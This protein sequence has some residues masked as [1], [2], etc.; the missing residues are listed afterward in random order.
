MRYLLLLICSAASAAVSL[1]T[2]PATALIKVPASTIDTTGSFTI[3]FR[4]HGNPTGGFFFNIGG[5]KTGIGNGQF[6]FNVAD[7]NTPGNG[8]CY[9]GISASDVTGYITRNTESSADYPL[10]YVTGAFFATTT[11]APIGQCTY[12]ITSVASAASIVSNGIS[13]GGSGETGYLDFIRWYPGAVSSRSGALPLQSFVSSAAPWLDYEFQPSSP[14]EDTSGYGQTLQ[15]TLVYSPVPTYNPVC[16]AGNPQTVRAGTPM[17]LSAINS[18]SLN[19]SPDLTF[20]WSYAGQGTDGV[21]QTPSYSSANTV[22][23]IAIGL[24]NFGSFNTQLVVTDSSGNSTTCVVHNGVVIANSVGSID[25][26][27]EGLTSVQQFIIGPQVANGMNPWPW[28]ETAANNERQLQLNNLSSTGMYQP[29]WRNFA[30]GT[31]AVTAGT[32]IFVGNGT[33]FKALFCSG[34]SASDGSYVAW[35]FTGTDGLTHYGQAAVSSCTDDNHLVVNIPGNNWVYPSSP[36]A[37][38]PA[39]PGPDGCS[40][41]Q[42]SR[43]DLSGG[44]PYNAWA[45]GGS[46]ANYYDNVELFLIGYWDSGIDLYYTGAEEMATYFLEYPSIDYYNNCNYLTSNYTTG[47]TSWCPGESRSLAV[48]GIVLWEQ[49]PGNSYLLTALENIA[50]NYTF[51]LSTLMRNY[52]CG[53]GDFRDTGYDQSGLSLIALVETNPT[54]KAA[55]QASIKGTLSFW[56]SNLT[57]LSLNGNALPGWMNFIGGANSVTA[58]GGSGSVAVANG[59]NQIVGTGTSFSAGWVGNT[60][61]TFPLNGGTLPAL[62]GTCTSTGWTLGGDTQQYVITAVSGQ[63][64][65]LSQPYAGPTNGARGFAGGGMNGLNGWGFLPYMT[66]LLSHGFFHSAQAMAGYDAPSQALFRTYGHYAAQMVLNSITPDQGGLYYFVGSGCNPPMYAAAVNQAAAYCYGT[67]TLFN[68]SVQAAQIPN[69]LV[70]GASSNRQFAVEVM[71][72]LTYDYLAFGGTANT[73]NALT[74]QMFSRAAPHSNLGAYLN[75]YDIETDFTPMGWYVMSLRYPGTGDPAAKWAGQ[76]GGF[77]EAAETWPGI[78][79]SIASQKSAQME[80]RTQI[81]GR[82]LLGVQ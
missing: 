74:S 5:Y 55:Y 81:G 63:T 45:N 28:A 66:G 73:L 49:Q 1:P 39:C 51:Y 65:T 23:T 50:V 18:Y 27:A 15:G 48:T 9:Y 25:E 17:Y 59:S 33:S 61:W 64:L 68:S 46:P 40:G 22:G 76:I 8:G 7:A 11:G 72:A 13:V 52:C 79:V 21:I 30:A 44:S 71:R 77:S 60:V 34:G 43:I 26:T 16:N 53:V 10:G 57:P 67:G 54:K 6:S 42:F 29:F 20:A 12:T 35:Q 4:A 58:L 82:V 19:G 3:T 32:N 37:P 75:S 70:V 14:G 62:C 41:L 24:T 47:G 80:G 69:P 36:H 78:F 2:I 31:L 56:T 38:W